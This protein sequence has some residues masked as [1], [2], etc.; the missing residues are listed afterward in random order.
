[1]GLDPKPVG[2]SFLSSSKAVHDE[3][4]IVDSLFGP[5][6]GPLLNG[7][8]R[9]SISEG[10]SG[11]GLWG[12]SPSIVEEKTLNGLGSFLPPTDNRRSSPMS[13]MVGDTQPLDV[14]HPPQSRFGW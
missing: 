1:M 8:S 9:L 10:F 11:T 5:T 14:H 3:S 12:N 6:T 13:M 7:L 2:P 4:Q